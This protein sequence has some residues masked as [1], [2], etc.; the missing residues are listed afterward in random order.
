M[1]KEFDYAK[2]GGI[3]SQYGS[4]HEG[5][6]GSLTQRLGRDAQLK[7][8]YCRLS[9]QPA[10]DPVATPSGNIYSRE[11]ILEYLIQKKK[12]LKRQREQYEAQQ[13]DEK[14]EER[15]AEVKAK[16]A[17]TQEFIDLQEGIVDKSIKVKKTEEQIAKEVSIGRRDGLEEADKDLVK[18][19]LK[20][21]FWVPDVT[22]DGMKVKVKE[23]DKRPLSPCTQRP[24]KI[25]S[26]FSI[27][28]VV[29]EKASDGPRDVS[30]MCP[31][32]KK[33]ITH[34]K[35]VAIKTTGTVMLKE[36]YDQF[37]KAD[38]MDPETGKKF[39]EKDVVELMSGGTGFS[40]H[41]DSQS[42]TTHYRPNMGGC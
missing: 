3:G 32:S 29:D 31:V 5:W 25:T 4:W 26:I 18:K 17:K 21:N 6:Q 12:D 30:Y 35:C 10:V 42:Q 41:Q 14:R 1:R 22:P 15:N 7:F 9:L 16:H 20:S 27:N 28:L 39:S 36:C 2:Y 40:G 11:Y 8:G 19:H 23:P 13:D 33:Q 38:M 37:V 24:L 34:Q